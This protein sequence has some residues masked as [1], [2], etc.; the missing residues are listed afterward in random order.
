MA[1]DGAHNNLLPGLWYTQAH[2]VMLETEAQQALQVAVKHY[3]DA[4]QGGSGHQCTVGLANL[5]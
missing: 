3:G 1:V 2:K 4:S 5:A